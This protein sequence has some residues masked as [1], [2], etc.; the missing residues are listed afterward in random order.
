MPLDP[1]LRAARLTCLKSLN[2]DRQVGHFTRKQ[3][4]K[5]ANHPANW[6]IKELKHIYL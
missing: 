5:D 3:K 6:T 1:P 2:Q 4:L